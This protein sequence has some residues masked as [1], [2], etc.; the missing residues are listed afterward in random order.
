MVN[1]KQELMNP[2]SVGVVSKTV[3]PGVAAP[4]PCVIV[5]LDRNTHDVKTAFCVESKAALSYFYS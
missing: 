1:E 4:A 5:G 2:S 3:G